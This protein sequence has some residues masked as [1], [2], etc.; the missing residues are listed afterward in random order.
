[1]KPG[2]LSEP[3]SV[4]DF[5]TTGRVPKKLHL[6]PPRPSFPPM[7]VLGLGLLSSGAARWDVELRLNQVLRLTEGDAWG[8]TQ[9]VTEG[10]TLGVTEGVPQG[11][12]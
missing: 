2:L 4:G 7:S 1:M 12:D 5:C 6:S 3:G 8:L 11:V 10:V 9:G